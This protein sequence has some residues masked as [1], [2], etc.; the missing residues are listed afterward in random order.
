MTTP[1]IIAQFG[2]GAMGGGMARTLLRAGLPVWGFDVDPARVAALVADGGRSDTVADVVSRIDIVVLAVLNAD[3]VE[4]VLFGDAPLLPGLR[5]G[6]CVIACATV[7]PEFAREMAARCADAGVHYLDAPM[8]GGSAKAAIGELSFMASGSAAA[9]SAAKPALDA[10]ASTVF[11]LG[12]EPGAGSAM[13]AVN[14]LLAGVHIAA[15]GEALAFGLGQGIDAAKMV[16]VITR[17]AGNSWMF[18]NRV[19]HVVDADYTPRSAINIWP[20]DLGIVRDIAHRQGLD[21]P[22]VEAALQQFQAAVEAGL[23]N[24]DDA[25]VTRVY[26]RQAGIPLP[27][28]K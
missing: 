1:P 28:D 22:L 17:S 2:L 8:S 25:A 12:D 9:F 7:A 10:M 20:K 3:Q 13:K 19:P 24:V 14:Q 27:G 26:T 21:V 5:P 15:M 6:A 16:E 11:E 23:G 4:S 18:E